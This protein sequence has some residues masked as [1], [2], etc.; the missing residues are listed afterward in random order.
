MAWHLPALARAARGQADGFVTRVEAYEP[1][2]APFSELYAVRVRLWSNAPAF[3]KALRRAGW[4]AGRTP[5]GP[6]G[7]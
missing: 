4:D 5:S 3:A 6:A 7:P 2:K 1:P